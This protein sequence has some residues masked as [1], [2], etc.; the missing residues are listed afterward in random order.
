MR[1]E[2]STNDG[3]SK[4]KGKELKKNRFSNNIHN[5]ETTAEISLGLHL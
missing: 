1:K 4:N 5:K 2:N 3:S